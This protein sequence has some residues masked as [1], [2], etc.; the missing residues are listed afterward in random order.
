[1]NVKDTIEK[2]YR[3]QYYRDNL[4]KKREDARNYYHR[5]KE[6][7]NANK[8]ELTAIKK[9]AALAE[10][11]RTE[12]VIVEVPKTPKRIP[13]RTKST[14]T[15]KAERSSDTYNMYQIAK[16]IGITYSKLRSRVAVNP[17]YMMPKHMYVML[18]G[19]KIFNK[20]EIDDWLP[21]I[22]ELLAFDPSSHKKSRVTISGNAILI[23]E[24]MR[25]NIKVERYCDEIRR[26]RIVDNRINNGGSHGQRY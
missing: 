24:F 8:R 22:V 13:K 15:L 17:R 3:K 19:S 26:E 20:K 6:V 5:N 12:G 18:D 4:D 16:I 14:E 11:L 10:K 7:T 2:E 21:Y 23:I 1:M 25:R 9:A